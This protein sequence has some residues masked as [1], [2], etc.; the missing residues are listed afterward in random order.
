MQ[1]GGVTGVAAELLLAIL[2]YVLLVCTC[3]LELLS[4]KTFFPKPYNCKSFLV[5]NLLTFSLK[6]F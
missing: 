4:D 5:Y 1:S 6:F 3:F 2:S